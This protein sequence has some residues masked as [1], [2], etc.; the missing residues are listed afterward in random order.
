MCLD[1]PIPRA[2]GAKAIKHC[3]HTPLTRK[4]GTMT[5]SAQFTISHNRHKALGL[6]CR[7]I[8]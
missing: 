5:Q 1:Y 3:K 6:S 2:E 4:T 8:K 7:E